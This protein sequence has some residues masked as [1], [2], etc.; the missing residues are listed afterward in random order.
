MIKLNNFIVFSF[1]FC[2]VNGLAMK[3]LKE[4]YSDQPAQVLYE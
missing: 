4:K 1:L 3:Q 2:L